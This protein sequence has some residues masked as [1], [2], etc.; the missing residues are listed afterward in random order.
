MKFRDRFCSPEGAKRL[1]EL[2]IRQGTLWY[3]IINEA[4][5]SMDPFL[6]EHDCDILN[7]LRKHHKKYPAFD[8][9]DLGIM[10]SI[11]SSRNHKRYNYNFLVKSYW[12]DKDPQKWFCG[13]IDLNSRVFGEGSWGRTQVEA[14]EKRLIWLIENN[15]IDVK[16]I[17]RLKLGI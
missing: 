6:F 11:N 4:M 10:L 15:R 2:G 14:R 7:D 1:V 8:L 16:D 5:P 12:E 3:W 13:D 9:L 17:N